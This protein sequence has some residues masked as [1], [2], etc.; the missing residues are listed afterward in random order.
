MNGL[1]AEE[2]Q[3]RLARYGPNALPE[4]SAPSLLSVFLRQFLSPLIYILLAATLMSLAM[5]DVQDAMFIGVVLLLNGAVGTAQEYSASKAA[6]ALR[7]LEQPHAMVIRGGVQQEID[8]RELVPGDLVLL[9]AGGRVP[10]DL[11]LTEAQ[12]LQCDESLLTGESV[13]VKKHV[14]HSGPVGAPEDRESVALAGT[15][16]ARGRG[17]G[18]VTATGMSTELGKI[19]AEIGKRSISQPPLI[20][21]M[22]HFARMIAVAVGI[23]IALLVVAGFVR[24]ESLHDLF[25]LSVGLAVS[26]IPEGLPVAISVA[27]AIA[28]RRMAKVHVI[29]RKMPAVESLGSCTVIAT[30]KTGTLTANELTV[31]DIRLPDDVALTCDA[32]QDLDACVIRASNGDVDDARNQVR[33]LLRAAVLSNEARLVEEPGGWEGIGDA[34][35]VALLAVA[36]K[37]GVVRQ[38]F[39]RQYP[40]LLRIPYEPDRRYAASFHGGNAQIHVFAKGAPETLVGMC[41]LMDVGGEVVPLDDRVVNR[42]KDELAIRGLRVLGFAEGVISVEPNR[43]PDPG[44]LNGMT[45]LGLAGMQD[46]IRSE[47]PDAIR[48]C[49]NAGITVAMIT[50]DDPRTAS[51]IAEQAGL[52]FSPSEVATGEDVRRAEAEGDAGLDRLTRVARIYARVEPT[53]KL[54][55]VLSMARNGHFVA[56]T[57]DGVND[58]PALKHAHVGIAMG[59]RGT[60]IAKESADIIVTDDNFASIVN[61]IL[62]GRVAYAN[63]RK[64][65]F[66]LVSTGA[67]EVVLFLLAIPT[68]LPMP[69]L[70]VQLLWLNL[71]TNGIQD[72]AL[73]AEKAE[74]DELSYPP[75][76]PSEPILDRL[77][78]RRIVHL[79]LIMGIGGFAVFHWLLTHGYSL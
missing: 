32:G 40:L 14:F 76:R 69:L 4:P 22:Q 53:Q 61:G 26:A 66:M 68:G 45:F 57:G 1:P 31:T 43:L 75:R 42:Q 55:I 7:R 16:I 77:M 44:N 21:R 10:A 63:I 24:G 54:A 62:E 56:V 51:T 78:I 34:V 79:A 58:G 65:I 23:A 52:V 13:P 64:V 20:I 17:H 38:E 25:M 35:D 27:L 41:S 49:H 2:V 47:V 59:R 18:V 46:P 70:P 67:A 71:V 8:S 29:V 30:D 19:A 73:A 39:D 9:E 72:V 6:A 33:G 74:G 28:M 36:R 48:Q 15:T 37:G 5:G 60:E 12:D 50:G 11:Q 3:A